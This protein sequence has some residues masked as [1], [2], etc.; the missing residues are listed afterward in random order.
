M[1]PQ[2]IYICL[3]VVGPTVALVKHG[4][5]QGKHNFWTS[6]V[7]SAVTAAILWWGGFFAPLGG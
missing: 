3:L 2:I 6:L 7:A 5:P 1:A 4:E